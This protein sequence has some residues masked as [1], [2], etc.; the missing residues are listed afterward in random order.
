MKGFKLLPLLLFLLGTSSLGQEKKVYRLGFITK[1]SNVTFFKKI[2]IGCK[3]R[4]KELGNVECIFAKMRAGNPHLQER[5]IKDLVKQGIDG[6]AFSVINSDFSRKSFQSYVPKGLPTITI[7][8]DFSKDSLKMNPELRQAY[9]GTDNSLLG[10]MLGKLVLSDD[11]PNK[12][13]CILSGH[14]Y[15]DNLNKRITSFMDEINNS[16]KGYQLHDRCPLYSLE[17]PSKAFD[18]LVHALRLKNS[19]PGPVTMVITGAWPQQD[20]LQFAKK[21]NHMK[22]KLNVKKFYIYS[23]DTLES[24]LRL[25]DQG[26]SD[27][28]VGQRP[29]QMG[30]KGIDILMKLIK[31]EAV[32]EINY[33]GYTYCTKENHASCLK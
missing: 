22:K 1:D 28:N 15:S 5:A 20:D 30:R 12:N 26:H 10:K 17:K 18:H 16:K 4:A 24:Q 33:T 6:L 19:G 29:I 25:L 8:A 27:G 9:I 14:R 13:L 3:Q 7:D 23:I 21:I 31:G 2:K 32:K 11:P